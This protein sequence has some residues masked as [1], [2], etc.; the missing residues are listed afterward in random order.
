[1]TLKKKK[2]RLILLITK[3]YGVRATRRQRSKVKTLLLQRCA[4]RKF[5]V[6]DGQNTRDKITSDKRSRHAYARDQIAF[7]AFHSFLVEVQ[8]HTGY[9]HATHA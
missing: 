3:G 2:L 9:I 8:T 7:C 4:L 1:M 5:H 6:T